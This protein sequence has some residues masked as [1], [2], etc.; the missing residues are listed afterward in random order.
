MPNHL[1]G[2]EKQPGGFSSDIGTALSRRCWVQSDLCYGEL[3]WS[4]KCDRNVSLCVDL[5]ITKLKDHEDVSV[6]QYLCSCVLSRMFWRIQ[7]YLLFVVFQILLKTREQKVIPREIAEKIV[8][9]IPTNECIEKV[10]IA[11]PGK[12]FIFHT[13]YILKQ[14]GQFYSER[15]AE[16]SDTVLWFKTAVSQGTNF[17]CLGELY[18]THTTDFL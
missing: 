6:P 5:C 15:E 1:A 17:F 18:S 13:L 14:K 16:L 9:N 4:V 11:G 8:K 3:I 7:F 12:S 10:E 2:L